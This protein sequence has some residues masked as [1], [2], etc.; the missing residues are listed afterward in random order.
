[1]NNKH[2]RLDLDGSSLQIYRDAPA[3]GDLRCAA[4]GDVHFESL[5]AGQ[6]LLKQVADTLLQEGYPGVLGPMNGDT[7]HNYRVVLESDGSAPFLMEPVSGAFDLEAFTSSG[8]SPISKYVSACAKLEDTLRPELLDRPGLR[9]VQKKG[10][11]IVAWDGQHADQLVEKLFE[12]AGT[13]FSDNRFFKPIDRQ[14]FLNIY[15]PLL[16]RVDPAHILFAYDDEATLVGFLFG[17]PNHPEN[18]GHRAAIVKTYA[19]RMRGVGHL[20]ANTY[21][22]R[23][24]EFG[25][26]HVIHALMHESN[27]S[28]TH[29]ANLNAT[30]FRRY[31]LL[32]KVLRAS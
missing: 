3:W 1:M 29:S 20:L 13:A 30:I 8:F 4:I 14:A 7:W 5:A 21:H 12:M 16:S 18:S 19:S 23:A 27:V 22:Q 15:Q 17:M 26:R 31:A 11:R 32:G 2:E 6:E 10:V 9:S 25:F 24:L 28:L